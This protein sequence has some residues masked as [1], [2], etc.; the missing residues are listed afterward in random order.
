MTLVENHS[1]DHIMFF[2]FSWQLSLPTKRSFDAEEQ[3][4]ELCET[5]AKR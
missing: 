2:L 5:Q 4:K 1:I 3:E